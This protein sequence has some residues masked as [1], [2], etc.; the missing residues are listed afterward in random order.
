MI[1][2]IE[3]LDNSNQTNILIFSIKQASINANFEPPK[4]AC[5]I[6]MLL[7]IMKFF[8]NAYININKLNPRFYSKQ[9]FIWVPI[10]NKPVDKSAN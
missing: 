5:R 7:N 9:H 1:S 4:D 2:T 8:I 6:Y 10:F 3:F